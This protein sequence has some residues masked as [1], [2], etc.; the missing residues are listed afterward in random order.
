MEYTRIDIT[1]IGDAAVGDEVI[2]IGV[3][4]EGMI[5][6]E[7][8]VAKQGAGRVANLAMEMRPTVARVYLG[9]T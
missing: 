9:A 6:P 2:I 8:V 3:Q 1:D 4:G 7:E 5:S